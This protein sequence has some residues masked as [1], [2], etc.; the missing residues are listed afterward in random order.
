M[1]LQLLYPVTLR[2]SLFPRPLPY[3]GTAMLAI[4]GFCHNRNAWYEGWRSQHAHTTAAYIDVCL[5]FIMRSRHPIILTTTS[6]VKNKA[7]PTQ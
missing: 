7:F 5:K 4:S 1:I 3:P 6:C 2:T